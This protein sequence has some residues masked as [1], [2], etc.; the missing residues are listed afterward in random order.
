MLKLAEQR[1]NG[2]HPQY[3]TGKQEE[4]WTWGAAISML[5]NL[6]TFELVLETFLE[7]KKQLEVVVDCAK[8][9]KFPLKNTQYE[10]ACDEKVEVLAWSSA[11][12]ADSGWVTESGSETAD[13]DLDDA[14]DSDEV[15]IPTNGVDTISEGVDRV[16]NEDEE[17]EDLTNEPQPYQDS[18]AINGRFSPLEN[19]DI[20]HTTCG[21]QSPTSP[22]SPSHFEPSA[23]GRPL[24]PYPDSLP[25]GD[26]TLCSA[27]PSPTSSA[28]VPQSPEYLSESPSYYPISPVWL[29]ET[30]WHNFATDYEVRV[31]RYRR[32]RVNQG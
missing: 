30:D 28:F 25:F 11:N 14:E 2:E 22:T 3:Q 29:P 31:V 26:Y 4:D 13:M 5:P 15:R 24:S 12:D 19:L 6:R 17:M 7:K 1:R 10:L 8:T 20:G 27:A 21:F 32:Q 9:W 18:A 16:E 23:S